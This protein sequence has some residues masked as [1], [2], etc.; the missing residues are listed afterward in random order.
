MTVLEA[1]DVVAS[2]EATDRHGA[3]AGAE[4]ATLLTLRLEP[5]GDGPERRLLFALPQRMVP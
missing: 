4:T 3:A 1:P 5:A 2:F